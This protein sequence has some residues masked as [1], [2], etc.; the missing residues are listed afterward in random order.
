[1][2]DKN[3]L[4]YCD[5]CGTPLTKINNKCGYELCDYCN[6]ALTIWEVDIKKGECDGQHNRDQAEGKT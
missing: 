5:R 4:R 6:Q 1:M 2:T 3:G